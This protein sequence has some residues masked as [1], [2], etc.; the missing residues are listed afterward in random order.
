[1]QCRL[2]ELNKYVLLFFL[3][4]SSPDELSE[5]VSAMLKKGRTELEGR[6]SF[7]AGFF[8]FL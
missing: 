3:F 6:S 2:Q 1:M 8:M 5:M 4:L 7:K